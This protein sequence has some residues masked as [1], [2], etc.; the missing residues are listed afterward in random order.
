MQ[1]GHHLSVDLNC[2]VGDHGYVGNS[3][4]VFGELNLKEAVLLNLVD[5][6]DGRHWLHI[7]FVVHVNGDRFSVTHTL[8]INFHSLIDLHPGLY[9]RSRQLSVGP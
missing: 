5:I 4:D 2:P 9:S 8:A 7:V 3:V 6:S 1:D